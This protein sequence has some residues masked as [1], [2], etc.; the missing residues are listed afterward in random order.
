MIAAETA[1]FPIVDIDLSF[2]ISSPHQRGENK[3]P[4]SAVSE[5]RSGTG[6]RHRSLGR[7]RLRVRIRRVERRRW[8]WRGLVY[9]WLESMA[10]VAAVKSASE[11]KAT[12]HAS[13][14]K[15]VRRH[16]RT[17][18]DD[19]EEDHCIPHAGR[20]PQVFITKLNGDCLSPS[21][22]C[23]LCLGR[24]HDVSPRFQVDN[25]QC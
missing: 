25:K 7:L 9:R 8:H 3:G 13:R 16:C 10:H 2:C 18:H 23:V 19:G 21:C 4:V 12:T 6:G 14:G 17:E 22:S 11:A 24:D 20:L 5:N 1:I 15:C